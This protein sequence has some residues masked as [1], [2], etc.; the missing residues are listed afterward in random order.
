MRRHRKAQA[1]GADVAA[2]IDLLVETA[3]VEAQDAIDAAIAAGGDQTFID[4]AQAEMVKAQSDL[5]NGKPDK[6]IGHYRKAWDKAQK[7][8]T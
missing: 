7:A 8:V 5:D 4:K 6:A 1:Q 3:R 2:L